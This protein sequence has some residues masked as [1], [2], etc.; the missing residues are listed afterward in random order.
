MIELLLD[1]NQFGTPTIAEQV[2][3]VGE[4]IRRYFG[5]A[6]AHAQKRCSG[7]RDPERGYGLSWIK[8]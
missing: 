4:C 3:V 7:S 2:A 6:V 8:G 5:I 1:D